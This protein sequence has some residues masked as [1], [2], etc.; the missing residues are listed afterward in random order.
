MVLRIDRLTTLYVVD[1]ILRRTSAG[2]PSISILMYHSIADEDEA[3]IHPYYRTATAPSVFAAQMESLHHAGFSVTG[4]GEAVRR[5]R[6]P[7]AE[8]SSVV[9][10]FDDGYHNFYANAFPVLDRYGFTATMFLPTAYIGESRLTFKG[11]ECLSWGEVRELQKHGI[12]FGSHTVTHPQLH[13]CDA[14][15][16]RDEIM[17]SKQ[18]IEQKLGCAIPSFSYPYAFPETDKRFKVRLRDELRHAEYENGV[19]TT[20][21]H[22]GPASDAY[23]LKRLP[24]NSD[25]DPQLFL[26]KLAGSYDWLAKPQYLVKMAKKWSSTAA[27]RAT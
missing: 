10:T 9:I 12:S 14:T 6:Q 24:V 17:G 23:F 20:V 26:A 3:G 16:I 27:H 8:R 21:G 22:P 19:C 18:T 7:N 25:D 5:C 4:L 2:K 13:D 15:S 11:K 1:P